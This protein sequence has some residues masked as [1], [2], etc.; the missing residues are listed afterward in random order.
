M[1]S[2]QLRVLEDYVVLDMILQFAGPDQWLFLG[3]VS[4]A[5]AALYL[6]REFETVHTSLPEPAL[7]LRRKVTSYRTAAA[8]LRRTFYAFESDSTFKLEARALGK[9]AAA[10]GGRE[11]ISWARGAAGEK[12]WAQWHVELCTAAA[13]GNQLATLKWL[14][15]AAGRLHRAS[16]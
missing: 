8:S 13:A 6:S 1:K 12:K 11:V 7:L 16:L 2:A 4:K 3:T 15:A 5:W 9:A 10:S 14:C